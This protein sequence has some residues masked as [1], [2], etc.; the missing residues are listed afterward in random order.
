MRAP[1][2]LNPTRN[3]FN[4]GR[5]AF[6]PTSAIDPLKSSFRRSAIVIH[7]N[8]FVVPEYPRARPLHAQEVKIFSKFCVNTPPDASPSGIVSGKLITSVAKSEKVD[9]TPIATPAMVAR[10]ICTMFFIVIK[11][12][13]T[14][15]VS[16][17]RED[18]NNLCR[19]ILQFIQNNRDTFTLHG[20]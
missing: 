2:E 12:L 6:H 15:I 17:Y 1:V 11:I 7:S 18:C 16:Y 4:S 19:R 10:D 14:F 8:V 20:N 9:M 3:S 5:Q 13:F